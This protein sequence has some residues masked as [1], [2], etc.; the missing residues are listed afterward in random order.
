MIL[1]FI[2]A[3]LVSLVVAPLVRRAALRWGLA[4]LPADARHIHT[5]PVPRLGGVAVFVATVAGV[6]VAFAPV[7]ASAPE[8]RQ[9]LLLA[10]LFGGAVLFCTGLVDDVRG[11]RPRTKLGIQCVAATAVYAIGV[12]VEVL[13]LGPSTSVAIAWLSFPV[14]VL[15]LV[16]VTNAFNLIDGLD[17]LATG[18]ALVVLGALTVSATLLHN[19]DVVLVCVALLGALA[20]FLRYNLTPARLFLGDSGSLFVGFML[21]VLS[22]HGSLKSATTVVMAVPV[23]ALAVPL[24]DVGL[25]IVRRWLRGAPIFGA[26]ARHIH[27]RLL[28][29]GFGPRRAAFI[30]CALAAV[31]AAYGL[32]LAFAPPPAILAVSLAGGAVALVL[33]L[34]GIRRLDYLEFVEAGAALASGVARARRVVHDQIHARETAQLVARVP[35]LTAL[36]GMLQAQAAEFGFLRMEVGQEA[37]LNART[38]GDRG[39]ARPARVWRMDFPVTSFSQDDDEPFLLRIWCDVQRSYRPYAA[40][41]VA[42]VVGPAVEEWIRG[43]GLLGPPAAPP[44]YGP[45]AAPYAGAGHTGPARPTHGRPSVAT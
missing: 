28:A 27:H 12:R 32:G 10:I 24:L 21:A 8:P 1:A 20:G 33:V 31:L 16:G 39:E 26:D 38:R 15:W 25:A 44:A 22:V 45:D 29:A 35:S 5:R 43:G 37:T 7:L 19:A 9:R 6:L 18:I 4:N 41:R 3:A 11:L 14:T 2:T 34:A 36:N 17:G 23:F 30:L 42:R 40:E 13:S